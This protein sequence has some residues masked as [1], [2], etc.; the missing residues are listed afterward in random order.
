MTGRGWRI[1]AASAI[2]TSHLKQG[3][4]CQDSHA[5]RI[6]E[7]GAGKAVAVLVVSDGAGSAPRADKGSDLA[8][9][10]VVEAVEVFLAEGKRVGDI[11]LDVA[12]SWIEMCQAAIAFQ[13][14]EDGA[15]ARDYACTL[16]AA[17]VGDS[18]AAFLQ[19]GDGAMVVADETGEWVW[20]HW[21]QRGDYANTTYFVT[22]DGAADQLAFDLVERRVDEVSVFSDGIEALVLHYATKTVHAP[23]FDRMFAPVRASEMEGLDRSLS[24]G[25]ERYLATPLVCERTDDDKTLILATRRSPIKTDEDA[26]Q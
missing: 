13:A 6:L 17:V 1:A 22:E 12:R 8:C 3:T 9:R 18:A 11:G 5:C 14:D 2:G 19:I 15:T 20:V 21:P 25:L 16:L 4:I 7:D 23:F 26:P 24:A 10:T